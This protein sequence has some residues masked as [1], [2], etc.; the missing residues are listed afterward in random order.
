MRD[1]VRSNTCATSEP[2]IPTARFLMRICPGEIGVS[3]CRDSEKRSGS[4]LRVVQMRSNLPFPWPRDQHFA[5]RDLPRPADRPGLLDALSNRLDHARRTGGVHVRVLR[6]VAHLLGSPVHGF[7]RVVQSPG[8]T[9]CGSRGI[10]LFTACCERL[11]ATQRATLQRR[12]AHLARII[13]HS[14]QRADHE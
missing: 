10:G 13:A 12:R 8:G 7:N 2:L 11:S 5:L 4:Y 14:N 1:V 6:H 9:P 3:K